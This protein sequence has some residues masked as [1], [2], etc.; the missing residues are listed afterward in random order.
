MTLSSAAKEATGNILGTVDL[1][2]T[3]L[4]TVPEH[5]RYREPA[6]FFI[7]TAG[8]VHFPDGATKSN[9]KSIH[10]VD[11]GVSTSSDTEI[12]ANVESSPDAEI[13]ANVESSLDAKIL[14]DVE[15][16]DTER[17]AALQRK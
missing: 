14:A 16:S 13:L 15:T 4:P 12:L 5:P 1:G 2:D 17:I 9:S 7:P 10:V 6:P 11:T 3:A 8:I